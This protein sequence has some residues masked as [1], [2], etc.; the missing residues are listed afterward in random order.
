MSVGYLAKCARKRRHRTRGEAEAHRMSMVR[1][2]RWTVAG[3]NTYF[4]NQCGHFHAGGLGR[5]NR[6]KGRKIKTRKIHHVQ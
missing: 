3:S 6:G 4:C 2:G 1:I 5:S